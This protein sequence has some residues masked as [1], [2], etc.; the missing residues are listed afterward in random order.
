V[1][2][3]AG[4][5]REA[6]PDGPP[7]VPVPE[8]LC[9]AAFTGLQRT[10]PKTVAAGA[11]AV[12][13]SLR[14]TVG[15]AGLWRGLKALRVLNQNGGVDC[16]SCAWP[17]PDTHRSVTELCENGAKAVAWEADSRR[18][19][20]DFFAAHSVDELAKES[21]Y[22]HGQQGRLTEPVVLRP[23]RRHYEPI[24][25][26]DAFRLMADELN[27][28]TSPDEAVF[29]TSGRASNEAAFLYQLF[30]VGRLSPR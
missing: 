27:A 22:W 12:A 4:A 24:G 28:L 3:R 6:A 2:Q 15:R 5:N 10:E 23:G 21:D 8:A 25:W 19:T 7:T 30:R 18:L 29:Y 14:H 26:D 17:D 13:A 11:Q 16:P 20:P 9:P 1:A